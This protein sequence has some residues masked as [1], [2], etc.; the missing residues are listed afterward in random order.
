MKSQI[1]QVQVYLELADDNERNEYRKS[2]GLGIRSNGILLPK[3]QKKRSFVTGRE[4]GE[5]HKS[6]MS[7][8]VVHQRKIKETTEPTVDETLSPPVPPKNLPLDLDIESHSSENKRHS[9]RDSLKRK[10]TL[11]R[12]STFRASENIR[13]SVVHAIDI[14]NDSKEIPADDFYGVNLHRKA[15]MLKIVAGTLGLFVVLLIVMLILL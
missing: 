6:W 12:E 15:L 1:N 4:T 13:D 8:E 3:I 14:V 7:S 11:A 10:A 5:E 2:Q 9:I